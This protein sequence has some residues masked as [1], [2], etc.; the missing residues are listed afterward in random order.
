MKLLLEYLAG[1]LKGLNEIVALST[2][3]PGHS[4]ET[5]LSDDHFHTF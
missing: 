1:R 2:R 3:G 4:A 5:E